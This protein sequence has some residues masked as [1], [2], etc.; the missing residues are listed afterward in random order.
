M[1]QQRPLRF[2]VCSCTVLCT[3]AIISL[4]ISNSAAFSN[5]PAAIVVFIFVGFIDVLGPPKNYKISRFSNI[6]VI[7]E[8]DK[9]INTQSSS[10]KTDR[11][12]RRSVNVSCV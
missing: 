2:T 5:N 12:D 3:E 11:R 8:V 4:I 6:V 9:T 7:F 10:V 1:P